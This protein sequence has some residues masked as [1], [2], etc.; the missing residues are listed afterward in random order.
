M[1]DKPLCSI[2]DCG[3]LIARREW[4]GAHYARWRIHG[5][6]LGGGKSHAPRGAAL[7]EIARAIEMAIPS[8]CWKWPL[9]G[10]KGYGQV[11]IKKKRFMAHRLVCERVHGAAPTAKHEAAHTCG[12]GHEG[13]INP[14][15]LVWKTRK[16]NEAD[17][18]IHGTLPRGERNAQAKLTEAAAREIRRIYG[19]GGVSQA[20]LGRRYGVRQTAIGRIIL[21]Q[22]WGWLK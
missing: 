2:P 5:H 11:V 16:E 1:A 12:K 19:A 3:K 9:S 6:P 22:R 17:K 18:A 4:C 14:H 13:C 21:G 10:H 20:E 8:A 15:H 7:E